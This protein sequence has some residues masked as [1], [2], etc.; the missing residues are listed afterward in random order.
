MSEIERQPNGFK[1]EKKL[2]QIALM[3]C[4]HSPYKYGMVGIYISQGSQS[5]N[6]NSK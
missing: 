3:K 5:P 1:R 6:K 2:I 4:T